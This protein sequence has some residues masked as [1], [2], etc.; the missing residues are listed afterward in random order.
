MPCFLAPG[1]AATPAA[2]G[3]C[4]AST[5]NYVADLPKLAE[6]HSVSWPRKQAFVTTGNSDVL[7]KLAVGQS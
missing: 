1:F 2:A 5:V 4:R 3:F 6:L 7:A